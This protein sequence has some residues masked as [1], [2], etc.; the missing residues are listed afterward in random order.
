MAADDCISIWPI[1]NCSLCNHRLK[2]GNATLVGW[3]KLPDGH[4]LRSTDG[5][6][7]SWHARRR[8][9]SCPGIWKNVPLYSISRRWWYSEN[10][11]LIKSPFHGYLNIIILCFQKVTISIITY[12]N[13]PNNPFLWI[14]YHNLRLQ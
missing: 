12:Q 8:T 2:L 13:N 3:P 10:I 7:A 6:G 11:T 5:G 9:K 4:G 14:V 1:L